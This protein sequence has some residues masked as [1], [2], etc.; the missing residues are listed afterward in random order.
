MPTCVPGGVLHTRFL[1]LG[2]D[3]RDVQAIDEGSA[4]I[5]ALTEGAGP[6]PLFNGVR[7]ITVA[8]LSK[9]EVTTSG[10]SVVVQAP[11]FTARLRHASARTEGSEI[12]LR[13]TPPAPR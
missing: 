2:N 10:D 11:G 1:Q 7:R 5:E 8:G 4:D 12:R 9:P 6:H 13:L 3:A